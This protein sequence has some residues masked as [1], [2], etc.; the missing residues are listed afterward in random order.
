M[1]NPKVALVLSAIFPGLGQLDNREL[2][3]GLGF[4]AVGLILG[5]MSTETISLDA[6]L[7]G[8]PP[9]GTGRFVAVSLLLFICYGL[10]MVDAYRSA[11]RGRGKGFN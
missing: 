1:R 6:L 9:S 3:K 5:W 8:E 10:S 4:L 7:A 2:W 11:R